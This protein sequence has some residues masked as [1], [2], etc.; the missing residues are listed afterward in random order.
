[1]INVFESGKLVFLHDSEPDE[2]ERTLAVL[3]RFPFEMTIWAESHCRV[4]QIRQEKT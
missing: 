2:D 4:A 3:N 1:M